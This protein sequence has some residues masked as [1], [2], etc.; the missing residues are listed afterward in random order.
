[1]K[2]TVIRFSSL[3]CLELLVARSAI[4]GPFGF[5]KSD[6]AESLEFCKPIK[7]QPSI[8]RCE[9]VRNPHPDL[10]VYLLQSFPTTGICW[11][12]ATTATFLVNSF[13]TSAR[14]RVDRIA[15]QLKLS[16]SDNFKKYDF[17]MS[18]SVWSDP[19]YW[20]IGLLKDERTYAYEWSLKNK[21]TMKDGVLT[22][23]VQAN[24]L[25]TDQAYVAV[26]YTFDNEEA[27]S[28]A[29]INIGAGAL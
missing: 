2:N 4:A 17:L 12:K 6:N 19:K 21:S 10:T 14:S 1:M 16:Y 11:I 8:Y 24:A 26:N 7:D 15:D 22:V 27:C 18:G 9:A 13:G 23:S 28:K 20:T 5:S 25:S 3:I 29:R